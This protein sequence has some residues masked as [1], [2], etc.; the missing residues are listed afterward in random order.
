MQRAFEDRSR[1]SWLVPLALV[2]LAL[3]APF[4]AGQV[5]LFRDI[6]HFTL[7]AQVFGAAALAHGR[8][9]QWNPLLY[10]GAPFFA[11]LGSG[12]L[13]PPNWLFLALPPSR[14]ATAF[15]LVHLPVAAAGALLLARTLG[16]GPLA[17]AVAATAWATSGYLLSMHGGHYYF[18]AAA[19]LPLAIALLARAA[20]SLTVKSL[21]PAS[22]AV[23]LLVLNGELQTAMFAG[24]VALALALAEGRRLARA[25]ATAGALALG[26]ALAAV[27]LV[28]AV[29]FA[30]LTVR[31][32]GISADRAS[33]WSLHPAR[34]LELVAPEPFGATWPDNGYW[35]AAL[36]DGPHTAPWAA[37]L[38]V[39]PALVVLAATLSWRG[40]ARVKALVA[41]AP[42]AL[43]LAAGAHTPIFGWWLHL[44]PLANR[45]RFPEKFAVLAALAVCVAGAWALDELAKS[46]RPLPARA[47]FVLSA[48]LALA[49]ALAL[50]APPAGLRA[51]VA[52]GLARAQATSTPDEALRA[53]AASL[54]HGALVSAA[55][56]LLFLLAR[57]RPAALLPLALALVAVDGVATG[58]P[59][60]S[61]G[62]GRFLDV[63]PPLA[64][65]LRA[66]M[67]PGSAG[68]LLRD[69]GCAY[70]GGGEGSLLERVRAWDWHAGKENFPLLWGVPD[71]LG[72]GAAE[73][74]AKVAVWKTLASR[75]PV[76][77]ARAFGAAVRVACPGPGEPILEPIDQP[78][79]RASVGDAVAAVVD[80]SPERVLVRA[81]GPGRLILRDTLVP[82]WSAT[83]DGAP[84]PLELADGL[85][86]AVELGP[87]THEVVFA[88]RTPGL[89]AGALVSL[90]ALA[91]VAL[92]LARRG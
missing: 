73:L 66:A 11:E 12:A 90:L 1:L 8:L 41:V 21:A 38:Y 78:L 64:A 32:S 22:L 48:L 29:L 53:L 77:A 15:V 44:V 56:G 52:S 23:A 39:A 42:V 5:L 35:G 36:L 91:A 37:S 50:V 19:L 47:A 65:R 84:A 60:L 40:P 81:V 54:A 59:V 17:S 30:R 24:L 69:G 51:L 71:A 27:Q 26:A 57:L 7:P 58:A 28:P 83:L 89:V 63:E 87:G 25:A 20:D 86:R 61:F 80:E 49:A 67:P 16:A 76:A 10:G 74:A 45:F 55:A 92:A 79:P 14:A 3:A 85:W 13:Y 33:L 31:A 82:G 2:P 46:P 4:F 9:P 62:D 75:D 43:L 68:R 18:A 6:L 70:R 72:Y 88:Y 34:W